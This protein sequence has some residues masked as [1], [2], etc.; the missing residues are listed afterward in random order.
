MHNICCL[1]VFYYVENSYKLI[2]FASLQ[3]FIIDLMYLSLYTGSLFNSFLIKV[4]ILF[5]IFKYFLVFFHL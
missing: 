2:K 4:L 5:H 1:L 3:I